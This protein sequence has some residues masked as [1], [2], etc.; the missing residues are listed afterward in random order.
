MLH[1]STG[2]P[3]T[4]NPPIGGNQSPSPIPGHPDGERIDPDAIPET[5]ERLMNELEGAYAETTLRA[6]RSDFEIFAA[7]CRRCPY[8]ALPAA[9]QTIS[10]FIEAAMEGSSAATIRRRVTSIGRIHR[11][12]ELPDPTKA[13]HVRLALRRMHRAKGRRQKQALGMT[14]ELRDRLLA[15][16]SDDL[17]G[18]RDRVM[19]SLAYDTL[20]RRSELVALRIEELE[21]VAQGGAIIPVRRSKSDQEGDGR[22]AYVS[23]RT[24]EYVVRWAKQAKLDTGPIVR[25]V[26]KSGRIGE[27][28]YPGSV[29]RIF[30]RLGKR[31][32]LEN[33]V[34]KRLS[35]HSARIGAAQDM[36]AA[37]IDILALMQ[38]GGWQSPN[39]VGRYIRKLD[40]LRGGGFRLASQQQEIGQSGRLPRPGNLLR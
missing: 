2:S 24:L 23:P 40:V 27:S 33:Q 32:G 17:V 37:G 5:L 30:K 15:A 8:D 9:P 34:V 20:C 4:L 38:A 31:A 3:F 25:S 10:K 29:G 18:L 21:R 16:A 13:E 14:A 11:F 19:V 36:A 35:S 39:I 28:L 1:T 6:Y 26:T 7:W 12:L 22:M